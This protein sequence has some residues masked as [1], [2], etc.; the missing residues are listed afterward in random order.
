MP[1]HRTP[2]ALNRHSLG[3]G[4]AAY[5]LGKLSFGLTCDHLVTYTQAM[6]EVFRALAD[7]TRRR[8]LD[9]LFADD[10]QTLTALEQR[11]EMSRF[12][13]MKHLRVLEE[14]G[15]VVTRRRGREKLHFLNAVP[16]RLIHDRWVSKYAEPWA[17][18]LSDIK[19]RLEDRTMEKVFEIYIKT[20]PERLWQAITD[21]DL[22]A[23]YT[24]GMRVQSDFTNGS[25]FE[26]HGPNGLLTEGENLEV[27]PP[28]RLVQSFNALWSD[29]VRAVGPSRVTWS[30]EQVQDSCRL[31]VMHDQLPEDAHGEV[32]GGWPMILSGLKTLLE[33]GE[34]LTTPGS[35]MYANANA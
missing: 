9:E 14:A 27:D 22:R 4:R 30:I 35:L 3:R 16:I 11:I 12:G 1:I 23:K 18:A 7:P 25:R 13:V 17:A 20:T 28:R 34:E 6:D 24:F 31:V 26:G 10:G 19:Q 29:E 21:P 33:T 2:Y 32:Y 8:L 15:L 5:G